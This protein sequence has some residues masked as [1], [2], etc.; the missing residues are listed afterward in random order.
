MESEYKRLKDMIIPQVEV[1][2]PNTTIGSN[3]NTGGVQWNSLK[4]AVF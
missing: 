2:L 3:T 4:D 1:L